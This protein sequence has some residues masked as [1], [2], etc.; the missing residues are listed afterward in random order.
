LQV[1][2]ESYEPFMAEKGAI[3]SS[4]TTRAKVSYLAILLY[5]MKPQP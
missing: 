4:L 3:L 5:I 2:D 1:G